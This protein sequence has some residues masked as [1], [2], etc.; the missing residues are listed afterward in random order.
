[1]ALLYDQ[2]FAFFDTSL[3]LFVIDLFNKLT[4][5]FH[6]SARLLIMNFVKVAMDPQTTLTML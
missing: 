2:I 1:M 4:S 3:V 5:V 6:T